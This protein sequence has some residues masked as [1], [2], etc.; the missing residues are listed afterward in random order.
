MARSFFTA[1]I[2][3]CFWNI[4]WQFSGRVR[5]QKFTSLN[6]CWILHA[7]GQSTACLVDFTGNSLMWIILALLTVLSSAVLFHLCPASLA[8]CGQAAIFFKLHTP[9]WPHSLSSSSLT[10]QHFLHLQHIDLALCCLKLRWMSVFDPF[11]IVDFEST[12]CSL[13]SAQSMCPE[14][15]ESP[16]PGS[17]QR[18]KHHHPQPSS[19]PPE[20]GVSWGLSTLQ[21]END[22]MCV[23]KLTVHKIAGFP[24]MK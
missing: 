1:F 7:T 15:T 16:C 12:L 24:T 10:I 21:T 9:Q 19:R 2:S 22:P 17:W 13:R 8:A 20:L 11:F 4:A 6:Q 23:D 14:P 18:A 5:T 3:L